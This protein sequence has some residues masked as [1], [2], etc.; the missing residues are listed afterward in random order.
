MTMYDDFALVYDELMD[1]VPYEEW[2]EL[3]HRLIL[4]YGISRPETEKKAGVGKLSGEAAALEEEKNL[5]LEL[6]CGTG[7]VAE[8]MYQ[9]GYDMIGIDSSEAMLA[10]ACEK[11]EKSNSKILYLNQEMQSF[12]LY[13]M[14][15]TIYCICDSINYLLT[16]E[17]LR[18]TLALVK[19]YL[20]PGGI[21]IFDFNTIYKYR[22]VIGNSTIAEDRDTVSFIWEN[23][24]DEASHIN[25][26]E[27]TMFTRIDGS[28]LYRRSR[29]EHFQRGFEFEEMKKFLIEAGLSV[30]SA[31][32]GDTRKQPAETSERVY[33]VAK[34]EESKK[35]L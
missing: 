6:G 30:V 1:N 31:F 20:F 35:T 25:E 12:E 26:Y 15:G 17:D 32:D 8:L 23:F 27:L 11:R 2:A 34:K 19:N 13:G 4:K 10:K 29:E 9:K 24:Y 28:D 3:L 16:D 22:E 7:T 21:F 33:V 5:V 18:E 14:V